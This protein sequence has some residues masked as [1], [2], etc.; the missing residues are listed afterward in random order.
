[1]KSVSFAATDGSMRAGAL[2]DDS[3]VDLP[4]ET[5]E[6]GVSGLGKPAKPVEAGK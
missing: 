5:I 4:G 1:M 6:I 3:V 2:A